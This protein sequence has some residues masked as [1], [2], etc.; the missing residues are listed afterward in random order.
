MTIRAP[1]KENKKRLTL[2]TRVCHIGNEEPD[3]SPWFSVNELSH[4][5]GRKRKKKREKRGLRGG[6]GIAS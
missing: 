5:L 6:R 2:F 4:I 3:L 1:P